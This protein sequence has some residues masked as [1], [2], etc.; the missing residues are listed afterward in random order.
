MSY[1]VNCGVE[2]DPGAARCPLCGTPAWKPDPDAPSYF[3]PKPAEVPPASRRAAAALLTAMLASVSLCCGVLNLLLPTER[4]WSLYVI[5]AAVMLWLWFV[6]PMLVRRIPI[7]FRLTADVAAVGVYVFLIS[8]DLSGGAWFRG[9]AL[10][11][12]GWACE[13]AEPCA[14]RPAHPRLGVRAGVP[15]ELSAAR[16]AAV[17]ALCDR[18]VHR[19]RGPDGAGRGILHGPFFPRGVAADVVA[20]RGGHLRRA[21]HPAARRAPRALAARGGPPTIQYVKKGGHGARHA[22]PFLALGIMIDT[23]CILALAGALYSLFV[24]SNLYILSRFSDAIL[25][26]FPIFFINSSHPINEQ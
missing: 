16:R 14:A 18:H 3:P 24:I 4:P 12:L 25:M 6:L 13:A 21:H 8:I 7:F 5:G 11:I 9:L 2:L 22:F 10:P 20:R 17:A 26:Y 1:C 15:F 19:H 23:R